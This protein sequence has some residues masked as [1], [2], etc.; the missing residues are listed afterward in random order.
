MLVE[1]QGS[2]AE[3]VSADLLAVP[4]RA[5]GPPLVAGLAELVERDA[6]TEA[7]ASLVV[8]GDGVAARRVALVGVG[9]GRPDELRTAA[10]V[11]V[12]A[13]GGGTVAWAFD[14][15]LP[16]WQVEAVVEGAILGGYDPG[17]WKTSGRASVER[18]VV[19]GAPTDSADAAARAAIV[20]RW[21]NRARELVDTPPNELTPSGLAAAAGDLLSPLGVRVESLG[22]EEILGLGMGGLAAVGGGSANE[23]RLVV[24]RYGEGTP[25]L[26]LV[27][28]SITFD[29]GGYFLKQQADIVRQKADMGGGAAVVGAIGAIAEL[30]LGIDV[31]GVLPAAENMLGGAAFRPGDILRTAAGLTVEV[32]NPDAEGRIVMADALWY[33]R[34]EGARRLVDVATL[35]GAMR[36]AM[37]DMYLGVFANDDDW[38]DQIVDAGNASGDHAWPWPLPG[39]YARLLDSQLADIK[40][41]SGRSFGYPIIAAAFLERFAGELPWAHLDIYS[42][43]FLDEDRDYF[44]RGAT[45]AGVRLLAELARRLA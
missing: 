25:A 40:N 11:A 43:A 39:R 27:G 1:I 34:R 17:R 4:V 37:G 44:A 28:K 30:G 3:T 9:E 14:P 42:V 8:Y 32:T 31:I 2:A 29:S 38:R 15:G 22:P 36:A 45:G 24:L 16:E 7:G 21:T 35:T 13:A 41:T 23:P 26:G 33:A 20:A 5:G 18:F 10:A 19:A 6:K 12:R